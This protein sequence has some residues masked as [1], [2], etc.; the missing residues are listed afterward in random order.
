MSFSCQGYFFVRIS[1]TATDDSHSATD[2][3][4]GWVMVAANNLSEISILDSLKKGQ[5]YS[6]TGVNLEKFEMENSIV[7]IECSPSNHITIVGKGYSSLSI[8]G[9]NITE[10]VFDLADFQSDWFR[11]TIIDNFGRYAWSNPIWL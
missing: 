6:S 10:A 1:L 8:H 3:G 4:G 5:F 7:K 11:L 9:T 2:A